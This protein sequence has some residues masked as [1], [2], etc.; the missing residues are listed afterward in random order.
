MAQ[1]PFPWSKMSRV[2]RVSRAGRWSN[3]CQF[4]D[5]IFESQLPV[6]P[7]VWWRIHK[8]DINFTVDIIVIPANFFSLFVPF[9]TNPLT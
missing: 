1:L 2:L 9:P 5:V 8:V 7:T 6:F 4:G 3:E